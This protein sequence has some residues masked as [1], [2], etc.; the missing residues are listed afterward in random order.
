MN[1]PIVAEEIFVD[2]RISCTQ[3][4]AAAKLIGWMRGS[5]R[6]TMLRGRRGCI[7]EDQ[8]PYINR[9]EGSLPE[10]LANY[11][12]VASVD[13]VEAAEAGGITDELFEAV[14]KY[15]RLIQKV[16][17]Y[18][19][20]IN[21]ELSLGSALRLDPKATEANREPCI[22]I[23]SLAQWAKDKYGIDIQKV[24]DSPFS[25]LTASG[26]ETENDDPETNVSDDGLAEPTKDTH[27]ITLAILVEVFAQR[28]GSDRYKKPDN[29]P[30]ID[31]IA[32]LI[33]ELALKMANG[34][35]IRGLGKETIR[36]HISEALDAKSRLQ[37][38]HEK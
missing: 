6:V 33:E 1:I 27:L 26:P 35:R 16:S 32:K 24:E 25:N 14:E 28:S 22:T 12:N 19:S 21:D 29:T 7:A 23:S 37:K 15:D 34:K 30:I 4:E 36:K 8:L 10:M 18:L 20:D 2:Q 38:L 17:N 13:L 9:L 5:I 31:P 3:Q 11:R